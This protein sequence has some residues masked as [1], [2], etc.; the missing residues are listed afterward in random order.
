MSTISESEVCG[1]ASTWP[2]DG[3]PIPSQ[4]Q[5]EPGCY[6]GSPHKNRHTNRQAK[7]HV[8]PVVTGEDLKA[9]GYAP[10]PVFGRVLGA[11]RDAYLD[12]TVTSRQEEEEIARAML[13]AT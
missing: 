5:N 6:S 8:R 12:G 3:E 4:A 11:L 7:R 1:F 10:G 13:G 9:M 2:V